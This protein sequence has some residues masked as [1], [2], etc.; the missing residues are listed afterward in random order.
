MNT[1]HIL[2]NNPNNTRRTPKRGFKTKTSHM[3]KSQLSNLKIR[4]KN[5]INQKSL[6]NSIINKIEI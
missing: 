1:K 2:L 5:K 4:R 3:E 6:A